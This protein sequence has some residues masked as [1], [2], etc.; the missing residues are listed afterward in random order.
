MWTYTTCKCLRIQYTYI[1][2]YQKYIHP[3]ETKTF[4]PC[5]SP[6]VGWSLGTKS[7]WISGVNNPLHNGWD[8]YSS[9]WFQQI[10]KMWSSIWL[11]SPSRGETCKIACVIHIHRCN[12]Y[13][14]LTHLINIKN[15]GQT[16]SSLSLSL[17]RKLVNRKT[18]YD[19]MCIY[20]WLFI[21]GTIIWDA[22]CITALTT[23]TLLL[24]IK[25]GRH[26]NQYKSCM[27]SSCFPMNFHVQ[28]VCLIPRSGST[29]KKANKSW[30]FKITCNKWTCTIRK[31]ILRSLFSVFNDPDT[32]RQSLRNG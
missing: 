15:K 19:N 31:H 7:L 22:W 21:Y 17:F 14:V 2:P 11:I 16:G 24:L 25:T 13:R 27:I 20:K 12:F 9:W 30:T 23:I 5:R 1:P 29:K 26:L 10:W 4:K 8:R 32:K 28:C 6:G 18:Y 3:G